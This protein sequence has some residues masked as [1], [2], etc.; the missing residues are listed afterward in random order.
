MQGYYKTAAE[1]KEVPK[2]VASALGASLTPPPD[3]APAKPTKPKP[4]EKRGRP[5]LLDAD[6]EAEVVDYMAF[7]RTHDVPLTKPFMIELIARMFDDANTGSPLVVGKKWLKGFVRRNNVKSV[8]FNTIEAMRRAWCTS[9]N[10]HKH[11]QK[12]EDVVIKCGFGFRGEDGRVRVHENKLDRI[13]SFDETSV[14]DAL[15]HGHNTV[16]NRTMTVDPSDEGT[17]VSTQEKKR[18]SFILATNAAGE[19][20][21]PFIIWMRAVPFNIVATRGP[22]PMS[23]R[24]YQGKPAEAVHTFTESGGNEGKEITTSFITEYVVKAFDDVSKAH[25]ILVMFDGHSTHLSYDLVSHCHEMGI[26]LLMRPPH[27]THLLQPEDVSVF[28]ALKEKY[29][30][31]LVSQCLQRSLAE[32]NEHTLALTAIAAALAGISRRTIR[33]GW[34]L[35]GYCEQ[36]GD[37]D[38]FVVTRAPARAL[39]GKECAKA[40]RR[41]RKPVRSDRLPPGA[42]LERPVTPTSTLET[43]HALASPPVSPPLKKPKE[44]YNA[45]AAFAN[46]SGHITGS[47]ATA[48]RERHEKQNTLLL[49]A[50]AARKQERL[51]KVHAFQK[52]C[53]R[54]VPP[55]MRR[56]LSASEE[57]R[58]KFVNADLGL[59]ASSVS[60]SRNGQ[61][62]ESS[63]NM[64]SL[65]KEVL[66]DLVAGLMKPG[67]DGQSAL[68]KKYPHFADAKRDSP[69]AASALEDHGE[70]AVRTSERIRSRRSG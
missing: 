46:F 16:R 15:L 26:E 53:A 39:E 7:L 43:G 52:E 10:F 70:P 8:V 31:A 9:C 4:K 14:S 36:E 64:S 42:D 67:E 18:A 2:E 35:A 40:T 60:V 17:V 66:L 6:Q 59:M 29:K 45:R 57:D 30:Q 22:K 61:P 19:L 56:W 50:E 3:A 44:G 49:V 27:T 58:S 47:E 5:P 37:T 65:R 41:D 38:E 63:H 62:R 23:T 13:V 48:Q 1:L 54:T 20:F 69:A 28:R 55:L 68:S 11:F 25:P 51:D 34:A 21:R 12:Y 24:L 33:R 32:D